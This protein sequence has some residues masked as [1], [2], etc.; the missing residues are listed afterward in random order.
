MAILSYPFALQRIRITFKS[1]VLVRSCGTGRVVAGTAVGTQ[2]YQQG[3]GDP[4]GPSQVRTYNVA[5]GGS[6]TLHYIT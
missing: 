1:R 5:R 2:A 4:L 3:G 6:Y